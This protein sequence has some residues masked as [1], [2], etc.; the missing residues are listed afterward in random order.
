MSVEPNDTIFDARDSGVSSE[1][2]RSKLFQGEI[3]PDD[4][5]DLYQFQANSGEE[6]VLDIDAQ[7][8]D[9]DNNLDSILRLFDADGQELARSDDNAAPGETSTLDSYLN[10]QVP[11]T[12][13]YYI[14]VSSFSNTEYARLVRKINS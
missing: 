14:G 7:E 12:G 5:I 3:A 10:F 13:V 9:P 6:I 11:N 2:T 4:D 8:L 1:E